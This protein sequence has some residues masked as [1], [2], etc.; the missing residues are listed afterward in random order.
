M[1]SGNYNVIYE[2][3]PGNTDLKKIDK[4]GGKIFDISEDGNYIYL[5]GGIKQ[6]STIIKYDISKNKAEEIISGSIGSNGEISRFSGATTSSN[7][8]GYNVVNYTLESDNKTISKILTGSVL[9]CKI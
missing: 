4:G 7:T 1:S 3:K 6:K 5:A 9:R 2:F 8:A